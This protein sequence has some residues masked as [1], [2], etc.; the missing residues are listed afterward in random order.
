MAVV[1]GGGCIRV[2][3]DL[4]RFVWS[5]ISLCFGWW[6]TTGPT[7]GNICSLATV[8]MLPEF[9]TGVASAFAPRAL[10]GS[11]GLP[12]IPPEDSTAL[13]WVS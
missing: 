6:S 2:F 4:F 10:R 5:A 13:D 1:V 11:E 7:R 3:Q 12:Q 9:F 8:G